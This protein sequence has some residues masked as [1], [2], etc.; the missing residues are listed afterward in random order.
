MNVLSCVGGGLLFSSFI[1]FNIACSVFLSSEE[2]NENANF[3]DKE[4]DKAVNL[5]YI[6]IYQNVFERNVEGMVW[7]AISVAIAILG[8]ILLY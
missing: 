1:I 4:V 7:I 2:Q 3:F 8:I 6:K 5:P